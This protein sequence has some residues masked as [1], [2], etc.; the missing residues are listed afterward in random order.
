[1]RW[2]LLLATLTFRFA[3]SSSKTVKLVV[4]PSASPTGE[5]ALRD[6]R[7][8]PTEELSDASE[9]CTDFVPGVTGCTNV[10][11]EIAMLGIDMSWGALR[12]K[13]AAHYAES[14]SSS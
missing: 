3:G 2:L 14:C 11:R 6:D 12:E 4:S 5:D 8:V 1:M 7:S 9:P 13:R 10:S